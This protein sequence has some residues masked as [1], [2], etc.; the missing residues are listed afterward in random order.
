MPYGRTPLFRNQS[1]SSAPFI[2]RLALACILGLSLAGCNDA[3]SEASSEDPAISSDSQANTATTTGPANFDASLE[4]A[5]CE[6]MP[7]EIVA[8]AF[9]VPVEEIE[10]SVF[11]STCTYEWDGD[12]DILDVSLGVDVFDTAEKAASSFGSTTRGMS[13]KEVSDAMKTITDKAQEAGNL[14]TEAKQDAAKKLAGGFGSGGLT[15]EDVEGVAEKARFGMRFGTLYLLQGNLKLGLSAYHGAG[16]TLPESGESMMDAMK[17]WQT[18][19]LPARKQ[20]S[21][22]LAKAIVEAL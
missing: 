17:Q 14:D 12:G 15:F 21:I 9:A 19:T 8:K 10:T 4:K 2:G 13:A 16:M 20:Q 3:S 1:A 22:E 6:I 18:E 5:P 7:K 11:S